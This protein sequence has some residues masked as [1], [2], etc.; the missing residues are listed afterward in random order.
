[1]E[2]IESLARISPPG[3]RIA[4]GPGQTKP[5][6]PPADLRLCEALEKSGTSQGE[7][8]AALLSAEE[9]AK[10]L[11]S[12]DFHPIQGI[13]AN[14]TRRRYLTRRPDELAVS[15]FAWL[16]CVKR[17]AACKPLSAISN[18]LTAAY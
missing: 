2:V 14:D 1:M 16:C 7:S 6:Q 15:G 4:S 11:I 10:M 12:T 17:Q 3:S 5:T 18:N 13:S 8:I 9:M